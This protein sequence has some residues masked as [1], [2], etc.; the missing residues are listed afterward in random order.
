V[1]VI[2]VKVALWQC[3]RSCDFLLQAFRTMC[4]A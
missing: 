2:A 4:I 1:M 3:D